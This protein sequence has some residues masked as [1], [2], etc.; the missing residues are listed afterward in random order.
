M[1]TNNDDVITIRANTV[2]NGLNGADVFNY[3][4][5]NATIHGGDANERY[6]SNIYGDKSGGD[7]LYFKAA[8]PVK[9]TFSTSEDG[10]AT[11]SGGRV[12][13]TGI[14]RI[15]LGNGNDVV[16]ASG[17]RIEKAHDGTPVHGLTIYT[18]GGHDTVTGTSYED[19]IDGGAGNDVIK[20]GGGTDFVQSSTGN[21]LIYGGA[22]NDNI[23][24]GQGNPNEVVGNDT[25]YGGAD[26]DVINVW[27][28]AGRENSTGVSVKINSVT[29][30]GSTQGSA[31]TSIG[32]ATSK[33]TFSQFETVWTHQ[34]RDTIDGSAATVGSSG[35]GFHGS[36]RWGDD[37]LKGSRGD[38][39]LEGGEGR[40]TIT[41]GAG[42]DL[43]SANGDYYNRN[44]PGDGDVDTLIFRG[45]FGHDTILGFDE[46]VDRLDLGGAS[47]RTTETSNGTLITI[48]SNTIL[49]QNVFDW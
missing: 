29:N 18:G 27:I 9:L 45:A 3:S 6:D 16:N 10:V 46:G 37:V 43:I 42:D 11:L 1:P 33:L 44:A 2:T 12:S 22:G 24:W 36:T 49:L 40:D 32:G 30:D 4:S 34:G 25:I 15:H 38:D 47:Y 48:G 39:T 7:R 19:F 31:S 8:T 41:G 13:F 17:A 23:R 28:N 20:A 21:D 35:T 5:G 14:E 26:S